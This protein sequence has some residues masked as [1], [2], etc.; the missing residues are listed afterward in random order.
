MISCLFMEPLDKPLTVK[1]EF[2]LPTFSQTARTTC[3]HFLF[4]QL[5]SQDSLWILCG[6]DWVQAAARVSRNAR[7]QRELRGFL[8]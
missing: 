1:I 5:L 4:T 6:E 3:R 8:S 7:A 2:N